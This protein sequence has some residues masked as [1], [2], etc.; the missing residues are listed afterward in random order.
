MPA[1]ENESV[2]GASNEGQAP[3]AVGRA[4]SARTGPVSVP[5]SIPAS[6]GSGGAS[7]AASSGAGVTLQASSVVLQ[8]SSAKGK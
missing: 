5:M 6:R 8:A 7:V 3:L 1:G 2:A 4:G